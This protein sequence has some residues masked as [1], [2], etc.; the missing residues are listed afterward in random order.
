[1]LKKQLITVF[2]ALTI[3]CSG[4]CISMAIHDAYEEKHP[5]APTTITYAELS[6]MKVLK[7]EVVEDTKEKRL[8]TT[9]LASALVLAFN[10]EYAISGHS[11]VR[12]RMDDAVPADGR[13]VV[14]LTSEEADLKEANQNRLKSKIY[15]K[16][17]FRVLFYANDNSVLK[18]TSDS[19][20]YTEYYNSKSDLENPWSA[21][22]QKRYQNELSEDIIRKIFL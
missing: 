10:K 14:H 2:A 22:L 7:I 6:K 1:M 3:L 5:P 17:D 18:E 12:A 16:T 15:W 4:G 8:D 21:K 9:Q 13:L 19:F 20:Y 11:K